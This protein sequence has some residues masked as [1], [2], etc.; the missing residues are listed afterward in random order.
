[1]EKVMIILL[2]LMAM[3]VSFITVKKENEERA[4]DYVRCQN[5]VYDPCN[6]RCFTF[7]EWMNGKCRK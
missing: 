7:E 4:L 2:L 6:P 5:G 1:M 3:L